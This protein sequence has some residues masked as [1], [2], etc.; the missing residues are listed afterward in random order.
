MG[1]AQQKGEVAIDLPCDLSF[2]LIDEQLHVSRTGTATDVGAIPP[3]PARGFFSDLAPTVQQLTTAAGRALAV[4]GT[5]ASASAISDV[6]AAG[7]K[8][9][10]KIMPRTAHGV[11]LEEVFTRAIAN[12]TPA[13]PAAVWAVGKIG[14]LPWE[15]IRLPADVSPTKQEMWLGEI[16]IIAATLPG[17]H[18]EG[19]NSHPDIRCTAPLAVTSAFG[20][21][22]PDEAEEGKALA[23]L[24]DEARH[25][26]AFVSQ[27]L[28][29]Q[30]V[31]MLPTTS[32]ADVSEIESLKLDAVRALGR[33]VSTHNSPNIIH[34]ACHNTPR[35][36]DQFRIRLRRNAEF[37][38]DDLL[39]CS[40]PFH[41]DN[42]GFLNVCHGVGGGT[43][44][45]QG[46]A[47]WLIERHNSISVISSCCALSDEPAAGFANVFFRHVLP[48]SMGAGLSVGEALHAARREQ[49]AGGRGSLAGMCYRLFGHHATRLVTDDLAPPFKTLPI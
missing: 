16:A 28:L 14:M 48:P 34:L 43:Q 1:G 6:E 35:E 19:A 20:D 15:L 32:S 39:D 26:Q 37:T 33:A 25:V 30:L 21:A 44:D 29:H 5:A 45:L 2:R 12:A 3:F 31:G 17:D 46:I 42:I 18:V 13:A 22:S 7:R 4:E 49:Y 40:T 9:Y 24:A 23:F 38:N 8:L 41:R 11:R 27:G 10:K 36:T 47:S